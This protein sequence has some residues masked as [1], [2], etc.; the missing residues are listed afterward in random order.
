MT[1]VMTICHVAHEGDSERLV[2]ELSY[3]SD[4][5]QP[6]IHVI[7]HDFRAP[8]GEPLRVESAWAEQNRNMSLSITSSGQPLLVGMCHWDVVAP[9]FGIRLPGGGWL[10]VYFRRE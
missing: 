3:G 5:R 6:Q 4:S 1:G 2:V 7:A 9:H 10:N 8:S